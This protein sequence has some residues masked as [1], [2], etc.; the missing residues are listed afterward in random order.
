MLSVA[1]IKQTRTEG[2]QKSKWK[3]QTLK[4][5]LVGSCGDSDSLLFY[6]PPS[7]QT[8]SCSN[9]YTIDSFSPAGSHF[10]E[11]F[12]ANFIFNTQSDLDTIHRPPAHDKNKIV[13]YQNDH[14]QFIKCKVV[15][16]PYDEIEPYTLQEI[17]TSN[18]IQLLASDILETDPTAKIIPSND[19]TL[20]NIPWIA[21]NSKV[22]ILLQQY[23]FKPKQ[24]FL[25]YNNTNQEWSFL[26]GRKKSNPQIILPNFNLDAESMIQNKKL[27]QGWKSTHIVM[28]ARRVQSTSN[29]IASLIIN[30]K[31]S[32][33][34][35]QSMK[36][37]TL[38]K[39]YKL[40]QNDKLIWDAAYKAEYDGLVN[41][42]TWELI[43]EDEYQ[44]LKAMGKGGIMPTM[45]ITTIKTNGKGEPVRAKY[46]I[47]ALGNLDPNQWSTEDCFAPV[48]SQ[49]ELRFLISLAVQNK[50]IPKTGDIQQAFCQSTLPNNETYICSPPAGCPLTPK[51]FYLKL[52]KTLY[53]L[54]RSPRHF[55]DLAKK[56]LLQ[57][58]FTSH[59]NSPCLFIGHLIPNEPPIYLGLYVDDFI[60]FSKSKAVE[61]K[62][63]K[64]FDQKIDID[65]NGQIDYFLGINFQCKRHPNNDVSILLNQEAFV[66]AI[67]TSA[68]LQDDDVTTPKSPYRSGYP[69]DNIPTIPQDQTNTGRTITLDFK[70]S[71]NYR[72]II[73]RSRNLCN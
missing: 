28:T 51:G 45:A 8:L 38:L 50:C 20:T 33:K 43:S 25:Q 68:N 72:S 3:G 67:V 66:D 12:D 7:K 32:A 73:S 65:W 58:G 44:A 53:G 16:H 49:L 69:V 55:Y 21:H 29:T 30:G 61:E 10:N 14:Q 71:I 17:D 62:F 59:P 22:T 70:T 19:D 18:I 56:L 47:V 34:D 57:L 35:L 4:C 15:E 13:Y 1:Y 39:H 6:H 46:R 5:I 27:F 54:K 64:E 2:M 23:N 11:D 48:L 36:A 26:P 9:G 52:R 24:G 60:Y 40:S 41:I 31:V 37:P 42:N 63:E